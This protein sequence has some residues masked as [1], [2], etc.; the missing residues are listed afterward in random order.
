MLLDLVANRC[1]DLL[2][3]LAGLQRCSRNEASFL[4]RRTTRARVVGEARELALLWH[5]PVSTLLCR[6]LPTACLDLD[7]GLELRA[8]THPYIGQGLVC[9][10]L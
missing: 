3:P 4:N 1:W 2:R 10:P 5:L 8:V 6:L 9:V 7:L